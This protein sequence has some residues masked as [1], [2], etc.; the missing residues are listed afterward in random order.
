MEYRQS[1]RICYCRGCDKEIKAKTEK[2][3]SIFSF[4]NRGQHIFL[5]ADCVKEMNTLIFK[6]EDDN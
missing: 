3:I 4:R 5:C 2:I 6:N 1:E